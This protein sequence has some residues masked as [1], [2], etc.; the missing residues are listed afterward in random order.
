MSAISRF[1]RASGMRPFGGVPSRLLLLAALALAGCGE[2]VGGP[3]PGA[4][5]PVGSVSTP[6][7]EA[8]ASRNPARADKISRIEPSV[9]NDR[10]AA[11][12][13]GAP[14]GKTGAPTSRA[15]AETRDLDACYIATGRSRGLITE[16]S[17][18]G[19]GIVSLEGIQEL[20]NLEKLDL[21]DNGISD[22]TPLAALTRLKSLNLAANKVHDIGPLSALSNLTSLTLSGNSIDDLAP[23]ADLSNLVTL[24][25]TSNRISTVDELSGLIGLTYLEADGNEINNVSPLSHLTNLKFLNV[26]VN[27]ITLG[28]RNLETLTNALAIQLL[29]NDGIACSDLDA[30]EEALGARIVSRPGTCLPY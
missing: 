25:L 23:L 7:R 1:R 30:L 22:L 18:T 4:A 28:V 26:S 17:C 2:G 10:A 6:G 29:G 9:G 15:Q 19:R 20:P 3:A 13:A 27:E 14:H 21:T 12:D 5:V 24:E 11:P 8:A 16:I